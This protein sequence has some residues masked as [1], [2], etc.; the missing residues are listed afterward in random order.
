MAAPVGPTV[1]VS[2]S[3]L[4]MAANYTGEY[5][6]GVTY[7][8]GQWASEE[9]GLYACVQASKGNAPSAAGSAYW[10]LIGAIPE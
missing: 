10:R 7:Q 8:K 9:K 4:E 5:N 1:V 6:S 2:V 3:P